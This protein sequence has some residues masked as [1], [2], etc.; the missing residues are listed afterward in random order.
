V[1]WWPFASLR[2]LVEFLLLLATAL[3]GFSGAPRCCI[4]GTTIGLYS[5]RWIACSKQMFESIAVGAQGAA[6]KHLHL[7]RRL[8]CPIC[9][10]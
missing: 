5:F 3:L 10:C 9:S 8:E 4:V 2:E 6:L 7:R 1:T